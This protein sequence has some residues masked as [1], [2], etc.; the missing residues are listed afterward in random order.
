MAAKKKILTLDEVKK[1]N[2]LRET[3]KGRTFS[4]P[5]LCNMAK[6]SLG[7]SRPRVQA[8]INKNIF[9]RIQR[10]KYAFPK[11]PVYKDKLQKGI[12]SYIDYKKNPVGKKQEEKSSVEIAIELLK[13]EGYR[14]QK[15]VF[16][17]VEALKNPNS[18]VSR[19]IH[20]EIV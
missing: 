7:L 11:E 20:W 13:S 1:F 15:Q 6:E 12:E 9:L 19:Y 17:Q 14:V 8:L 2:E 3:N 16:D 5:E 10:G 18:L 4:F